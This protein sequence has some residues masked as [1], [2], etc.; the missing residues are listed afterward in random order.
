MND[1]IRQLQATSRAMIAGS[2]PRPVTKALTPWDQALALATR[3]SQEHDCSLQ[4]ALD[5]VAHTHPELWAAHRAH[6]ILPEVARAGVSAA[7]V[8]GLP[9]YMKAVDADL[10]TV[11]E[12]VAVLKGQGKTHAEAWAEVERDPAVQAVK[13]RYYATH[14]VRNG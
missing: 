10:A 5:A 4:T 1:R 11:R 12:R 6:G 7:E 14:P 3:Y 13:H 8:A 9:E 2:T